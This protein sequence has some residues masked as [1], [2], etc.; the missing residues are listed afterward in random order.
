MLVKKVNGF[1]KLTGGE[2]ICHF[3]LQIQEGDHSLQAIDKDLGLLIELDDSLVPFLPQL[4]INKHQLLDYKD[5]KGLWDTLETLQ[6]EL[7][8]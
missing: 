4:K 2:E 3:I 8:C 1:E 5:Y 6:T 7:I